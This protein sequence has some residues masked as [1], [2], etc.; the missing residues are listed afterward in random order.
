MYSNDARDKL[1]AALN[2]DWPDHD[3]EF[4]ASYIDACG[5]WFASLSNSDR[6]A[7]SSARAAFNRGDEAGAE[8]L[9]AALPSAPKLPTS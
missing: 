8:K 4:S 7:A 1:M 6:M 2:H 3:Q 9:A 5:K